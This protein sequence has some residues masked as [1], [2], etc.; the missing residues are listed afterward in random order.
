MMEA[1]LIEDH[2]KELLI[3]I[4]IGIPVLLAVFFGFMVF[5]V[6]V[7]FPLLERALQ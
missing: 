2:R 5:M 4:A 1:G 3:F 7:Y 6:K